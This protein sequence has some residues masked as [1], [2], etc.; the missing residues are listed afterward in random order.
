MALFPKRSD[1]FIL[2][3]KDA[4]PTDLSTWAK[5][6]EGNFNKRQV[7]VTERDGIKVSTVFL[8]LDHSFGEG[9]PLIFET[10]IFGGP[11]DQDC[12]RYT[13]WQQAEEGHDKACMVAFAV[14]DRFANLEFAEGDD[15]LQ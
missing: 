11:H 10:M 9:P 1:H 7:S 15:T 4:V 5:W 2:N 13:T 12:W 3:G 14:K 6:F 8:G